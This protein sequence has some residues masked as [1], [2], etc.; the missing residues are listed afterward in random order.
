MKN[1]F[2]ESPNKWYA[3]SNLSAKSAKNTPYYLWW[4]YLRLSEDYWWLCQQNG[5]TL[6]Q[7]FA[8]TYSLFGDVFNLSFEK[9]WTNNGAEA[10]AYKASPPKVE[11]VN[12]EEINATQPEKWLKFIKIPLHLTKSEMLAQMSALFDKH[13]PKPLPNSLSP[14][15]ELENMR[16]IRNDVLLDAHRVWCL[17]DAISRGKLNGKLDR[18]ERLTQYWIGMQLGLEPEPDKAKINRHVQA[19]KYEMATVRVKVNRYISKARN[20]IANVEVGHFP[21][22]TPVPARKR[23]SEIQLTEKALAIS[24]GRW[25]CPESK[26]REIQSLLPIIKK[27]RRR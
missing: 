21:V 11:I 27:S 23:W 17:N 1:F 16:G 22:M 3:K 19:S 13:V 9:W 14:E 12:L 26:T 18:P 6:D 5:Q 4:R 8:K 24:E 10:F 25:V 15:N 20:I 2:P 7:D